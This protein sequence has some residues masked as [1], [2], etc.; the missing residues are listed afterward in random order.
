MKDYYQLESQISNLQNEIY[1]IN[2][3]IGNL[4]RENRRLENENSR[5]TT[6]L[7][8]AVADIE[9]TKRYTDYLADHIDKLIIAQEHMLKR[10]GIDL[11][12]SAVYEQCKIDP[13]SFISSCESYF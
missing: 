6:D 11:I 13:N 1:R 10:F 4:E 2:S 12:D 3:N 5:L 8:I 9:K 7:S